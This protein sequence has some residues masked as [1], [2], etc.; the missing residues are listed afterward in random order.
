MNWRTKIAALY[1]MQAHQPTWRGSFFCMLTTGL[2]FIVG[3]ILQRPLDGML[4]AILGMLLMLNDFK[5]DL[6]QRLQCQL[7]MLAAL[8]FGSLIAIVIKTLSWNL[9]QA[10]FQLKNYSL[11]FF[12]LLFVATFF[13]GWAQGSG[14]LLEG[15]ARN[16]ALALIVV[17]QLPQIDLTLQLFLIGSALLSLLARI[18]DNALA[19]HAID[20]SITPIQVNIISALNGGNAGLRYATVY[21]LCIVSGL[22]LGLVLNTSKAYWVAVTIMMTMRP[23]ADLNFVRSLQRIV[24]TIIGV[25]IAALVVIYIHNMWLIAGIILLIGL[26]LPHGFPLNYGLHCSLIA[27]FVLLLYHIVTLQ[28]GDD[29]NLLRERIYDVMMGCCIAL[30]GNTLAFPRSKENQNISQSSDKGSG[31][32]GE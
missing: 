15:A 19:A 10:D 6:R 17:S 26:A 24:G 11:L 7:I 3:M 1:V 22:L 2:P 20:L 12:I 30:V 25:A 29:A 13:A 18:A 5:G 8:L 23:D 21:S 9:G 27:L 32:G 4:G 16:T 31:S 14:K 28:Y